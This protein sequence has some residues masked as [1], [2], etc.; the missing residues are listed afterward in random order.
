MT[1][2]RWQDAPL[3]EDYLADVADTGRGRIVRHYR[4][5][6]DGNSELV[7]YIPFSPDGARD[8]LSI[9]RRCGSR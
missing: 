1:D 3:F 9:L 8:A 4:M 2:H 7:E 6:A 5:D